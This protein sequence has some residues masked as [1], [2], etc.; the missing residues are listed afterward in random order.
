MNLYLLANQTLVAELQILSWLAKYFLF[1]R[2]PD[3]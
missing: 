1:K 3:A 2:K